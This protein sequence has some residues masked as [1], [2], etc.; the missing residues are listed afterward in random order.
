MD[1]L[2]KAEENLKKRREILFSKDSEIFSSLDALLVNQNRKAVTLWALDLAQEG[3]EKFF[4]KHPEEY[5]V[6][7]AVESSKKWSEGKIKMPDARIKILECHAVAKRLSN[8]ADIALV[9][10]VAQGCSV[11]HTVKHAMGYPIYE[12]TSLVYE[13]GI[14]QC[15]EAIEK[16]IEEYNQKLIFF[17]DSDIYSNKKWADFIN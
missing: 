1:W 5:A 7:E 15:K 8:K 4:K 14:E 11:V 9:H 2:N 6:I 13:L 12:L 17:S 16:R 10:A 3:A